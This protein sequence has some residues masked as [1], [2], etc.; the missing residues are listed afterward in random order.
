[1]FPDL[2]VLD[3]RKVALPVLRARYVGQFGC[4]VH[5]IARRQA[6]AACVDEVIL[7]VSLGRV[8]G[9]QRHHLD[10]RR[11]KQRGVV[12]PPARI[13]C[14]NVRGIG[15]G[16]VIEVVAACAR[17][18]VR[19]T[20]NLRHAGD[21][22]AARGASDDGVA[23]MIRGRVD[24]I[25]GA[26]NIGAVDVGNAIELVH[27]VVRVAACAVGAQVAIAQRLRVRVVDHQG[28]KAGRALQTR[29]ERVEPRLP[30]GHFVVD[31]L[32]ILIW[33]KLL[34]ARGGR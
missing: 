5:P 8:A 6:E 4:A 9:E 18:Q 30:G 19:A 25:R 12:Y 28:E 24:D 27:A 13:G 32:V 17:G 29:L 33:T 20:F 16:T 31:I 34:L 15:G 2:E 11:A 7:G 21:F 1:M 22:P 3:R 10:V 23:A 26:Q 14:S